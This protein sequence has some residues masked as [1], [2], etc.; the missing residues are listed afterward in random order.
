MNTAETGRR[1]AGSR[2]KAREADGGA[3]VPYGGDPRPAGPS[4]KV[5]LVPGRCDGGAMRLRAKSCCAALTCGS[6]R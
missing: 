2:R 4:V 5:V 6:A 1:G 3:T